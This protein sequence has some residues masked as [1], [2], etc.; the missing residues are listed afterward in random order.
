[1]STYPLPKKITET[2]FLN[3]HSEAL[4]FYRDMDRNLKIQVD[5]IFFF[6]NLRGTFNKMHS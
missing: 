6:N 5:T 4:I 1:M 2:N 3:Q